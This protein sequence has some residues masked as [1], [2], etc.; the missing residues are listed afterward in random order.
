L[1]KEL[2]RIILLQLNILD[3]FK[4]KDIKNPLLRLGVMWRGKNTDIDHSLTLDNGNVVYYGSPVLKS[5][6]GEVIVTSS[7]DITSCSSNG[8][9]ST[10]ILDIDMLKL[11]DH[12]TGTM[13]NSFIDYGG[14]TNIGD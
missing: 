11:K 8:I 2:L 3:L 12:F 1:C 14:R 9:F 7:S 6:I 13:F 10:E 5:Q 4:N